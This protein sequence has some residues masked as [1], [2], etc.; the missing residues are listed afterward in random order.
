MVAALGVETHLIAGRNKLLPCLDSD[1]SAALETAMR[2]LGVRFVWNHSVDSGAAPAD[3]AARGVV[4]VGGW[5]D[6]GFVGLVILG[7]LSLVDVALGP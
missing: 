7:Q 2:R 6:S 1:L 5:E 3:V 4:P